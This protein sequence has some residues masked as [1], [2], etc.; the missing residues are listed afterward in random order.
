M[1]RKR[2]DRTA[3]SWLQ[4]VKWRLIDIL[5]WHSQITLDKWT[6]S[7]SVS[8]SVY[9]SIFTLLTFRATIICIYRTFCNEIVTFDVDYRWCPQVNTVRWV[10]TAAAAS[11]VWC[12]FEWHVT[13]ELPTVHQWRHIDRVP[14][15]DCADPGVDVDSLLTDICRRSFRKTLYDRHPPVTGVPNLTDDLQYFWFNDAVICGWNVPVAAQRL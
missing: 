8:V 10:D 9:I 11:A 1:R 3:L 5:I 15:Y 2:Q 7:L 14:V 13:V 12:S 4:F 6:I